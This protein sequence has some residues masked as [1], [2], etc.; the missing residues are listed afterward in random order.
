MIR[1]YLRLIYTELKRILIAN[2]GEIAIRI[3]RAAR[4][5]GIQPVAVYSEADRNALHVQM[6]DE[7]YCI[8]PAASA[9]SY[10]NIAA[11]LHVCATAAIDAVHPGYGFLSENA[12]F[13]RQVTE[14]GFVFIGPGAEAMEMMGSKLGAKQ[15]A[16]KLGVPLVPGTETAIQDIAEAIREAAKIGFPI[17]VKASAGGGG[18]GMR[19][20]EKAADLEEQLG[21]A[22]SEATAAFG[23]GSVFLER[24]ISSPRHIEIQVIADQHGNACYLF[25]RECSV[26]RRHQKVI[27]EAPSSVLT[28]ATRRLMGEAALRLTLAC[29]YVGAGTIEFILDED[30]NYYF[31]EMNTR[32]QVEHPVTEYIT[33]IDLVKEQIRIARGEKLSFSQEDL[34][35]TGHAIELRVSAEDPWNNFMPDTGVLTTYRLP[36]GPGVRVD[37]GIMEGME[38]PIYY[39]PM[40]SKLIVHAGTRE[41]AIERMKRAIA[42]FEVSGIETTLG[43]GMFVMNHTAFRSGKFDTHFVE[44]HFMPVV[45]ARHEAVSA[46]LNVKSDNGLNGKSVPG[47]HADVSTGKDTALVAALLGAGLLET[48]ATLP[49]NTPPPGNGMDAWRKNRRI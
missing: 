17:L 12:D 14:S 30:L 48:A 9:A 41:E 46:G 35:I 6:A 33:G 11:I 22:I 21:L 31:L 28:P 26:Q 15:V 23:D 36:S 13:A 8:G 43:F 20:V 10:L 40:L 45:A 1:A 34:K 2:R 18:K 44:R 25:E 3:I 49:P 5:M 38:V 27:E 16:R 37:N 4:E 39:D 29:G 47:I 19:L 42:E 7:A 32:L 24:Y